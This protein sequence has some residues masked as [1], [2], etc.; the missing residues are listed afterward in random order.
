MIR[1]WLHR[2][3]GFDPSEAR[4]P[5]GKWTKGVTEAHDPAAHYSVSKIDPGYK[6]IRTRLAYKQFNLKNG[7]LYPLFIGNKEPVAEGEW[8]VG[9]NIPTKGYARRPGWHSGELPIGRQLRTRDPFPQRQEGRVWAEVEIPDDVDWQ[10]EADKTGG[11]LPNRVPEGGNYRFL[12]PS[13]KGGRGTPWFISGAVKVNRRLSDEEVRDILHKAGH[14]DHIGPETRFKYGAKGGETFA[15]P[16][17]YE[18]PPMTPEHAIATAQ[19]QLRT[20]RHKLFQAAAEDIDLTLGIANKSEK[21]AVGAW[22]DGAEGTTVMIAPGA[23][24]EQLR[25]SAAMKGWLG[26]QKAVL[27]FVANPNSSGTMYSA[28]VKGDLADIHRQLLKKGLENH[29][30]VPTE[31]GATI[32]IADTDGSL[33]EAVKSYAKAYPTKFSATSGDAEFIGATNY[34]GTTDAEQRAEGRKAYEAVIAGD[35]VHAAEWGRLRDRWAKALEQTQ[36]AAGVVV[37]RTYRQAELSGEH[38]PKPG[39]IFFVFRAGSEAERQVENRDAGNALGVAEH[40]CMLDD[41][42]HTKPST[43]LGG[44]PTTIHLYAVMLQ[45]QLGPYQA[46]VGGT[47]VGLGIHGVGYRTHGGAAAMSFGRNGRGYRAVHVLSF[48]V[49]EVRAELQRATGS[50]DFAEPGL[51]AVADA[52]HAVAA[53]HGGTRD[54]AQSF[55]HVHVGDQEVFVEAEHPRKMKGP[56]GGEFTKKGTGTTGGGV[57]VT[58]PHAGPKLKVSVHQP[59]AHWTLKGGDPAGKS[60]WLRI[61]NEAK[62]QAIAA[63][64]VKHPKAPATGADISTHI[65][66]FMAG[67]AQDENWRDWYERHRPIAKQLYG[68]YEPLFEHVLAITSINNP[69]KRNVQ[70]GIDVTNWLL[71]GGKA[72][73]LPAG[74]SSVRWPTPESF[75]KMF[76]YRLLPKWN[77]KLYELQE[78]GTVGGLKI[79]QFD[80]ALSGDPEGVPIDR[81]MARFLFEGYGAGSEK[82]KANVSD[83][84]HAV[85]QAV[86]RNWAKHMGWQARELQAVTWAASMREQGVKT[87]TFEDELSKNIDAI[88]TF[89]KAHGITVDAD[90]EP[91]HAGLV[92]LLQTYKNTLSLMKYFDAIRAALP[93]DKLTPENVCKLLELKLPTQDA[94]EERLHPRKAKGPG[95]G[96]FTVKGTGS[97]GGGPTIHIH[98]PT[99]TMTATKPKAPAYQPRHPMHQFWEPPDDPDYFGKVSIT[100]PIGDKR[101]WDI[102]L[103]GDK[104]GRIVLSPNWRTVE[105]MQDTAGRNQEI[106]QQAYDQIERQMGGKP[107]VPDLTKPLL[108]GEQRFWVTRMMRMPGTMGLQSLLVDAMLIAANHGG[109]QDKIAAV[110]KQLHDQY[111]EAK[112]AWGT[113]MNAREEARKAAEALK[114]KVP[115]DMPEKYRKEARYAG[116]GDKVFTGVHA[117]ENA[118]RT[119]RLLASG[120]NRYHVEDTVKAA[121]LKLI[122]ATDVPPEIARIFGLETYKDGEPMATQWFEPTRAGATGLADAIQGMR[123]RGLG[124]LVDE[125]EKNTTVVFAPYVEGRNAWASVYQAPGGHQ[126]MMFNSNNHAFDDYVGGYENTVAARMGDAVWRKGTKVPKPEELPPLFDKDRPLPL[127]S[128]E[129]LDEA[130]ATYNRQQFVH[131]MGHVLDNMTHGEMSGRLREIIHDSTGGDVG[132]DE[133]AQTFVRKAISPYAGTNKNEA[134]AEAFTMAIEDPKHV[135]M[136]LRKWAQAARSA[137]G[138]NVAVE[139]EDLE[140]YRPKGMR[141]GPPERRARR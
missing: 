94:W 69:F 71:T 22:Q 55:L 79:G 53:R 110:A 36:D 2:D 34:E 135:P 33:E 12:E 68:K 78:K 92:Q 26:Q 20:K 133:A 106:I 9:K 41:P 63:Y 18:L 67:A 81:H 4:D 115:D 66:D 14:D 46:I 116:V 134:A 70:V 49:R 121:G 72:E 35:R 24:K 43:L 84:Q 47:T 93:G 80:A 15:S 140:R 30:L 44:G 11:E 19:A 48:P 83:L 90:G 50:D 98:T 125:L 21:S 117:I 109:N 82:A 29:T 130:R 74:V 108:E 52:I 7:K 27:S 57:S 118:E 105:Q 56:G 101:R 37:R 103:D 6:P 99:A 76:G 102:R 58:T 138:E 60:D 126:W 59:G 45:D 139:W 95:G 119:G 64:K 73:A 107:L 104:I 38:A 54:H 131:E 91:S 39:D 86:V 77:E 111:D 42:G 40:L 5:A 10:P 31:G 32:Y 88:Q 25:L 137:A 128:S 136:P 129:T 97:F 13:Q 123:D 89:L 132:I 16:S 124:R 61:A 112:A 51:A 8:V 17:V 87:D 85:G 100:D 114:G 75:S 113:E 23:S 141:P 1:L 127:A 65:N 122:D 28:S 3:A 96:E 120:D 62:E